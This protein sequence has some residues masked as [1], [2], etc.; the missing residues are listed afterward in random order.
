ME[1]V[2]D[3]SPESLKAPFFLRIAAFCI[4]YML[5]MSAPILWLLGSKFFGD[6][7]NA[8]ISATVWLLVIIVWV[9]DF[10]LLPLFRGQTFGKMLAGVT[11][12]N[13]DGTPVRLSGLLKRNVLGYLMTIVTLGVGFL[14]SAVNRTGRSL[15]DYVAGTIV[16][17]GRRRQT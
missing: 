13:K 16:V 10:L 5:V 8:S 15:H 11:I 3:F 14:I 2:I 12:V 1:K 17:Y 6:G 4:D 7:A 9:L